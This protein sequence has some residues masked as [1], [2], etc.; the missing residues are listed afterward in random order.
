MNAEIAAN[1]P[2][3]ERYTKC[4]D[5]KR[6][7]MADMRKWEAGGANAF[8]GESAKRWARIAKHGRPL[9]KTKG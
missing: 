7:A 9:T 3:L 1:W 6:L 8:G 4:F 2:D 5:Q